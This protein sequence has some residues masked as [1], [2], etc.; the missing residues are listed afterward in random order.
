MTNDKLSELA[1]RG[2]EWDEQKNELNR[3][4]HGIDFNDAIVI[5]NGPVAVRRSTRNSEERW[6]AKGTLG[7]NTIACLYAANRCHPVISARRAR[8]NEE[9]AY[10]NAKVGRPPEG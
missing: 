9:R 1:T 7:E 5:F 8:K 2:F 10:R 6:V 4:K 3:A